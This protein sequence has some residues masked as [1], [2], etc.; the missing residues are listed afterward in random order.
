M[1]S[2]G[3]IDI[4]YSLRGSCFG[5]IVDIL[6]SWKGVAKSMK[7]AGNARLA[8]RLCKGVWIAEEQ[9]L[10]FMEGEVGN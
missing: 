3:R 8:D 1:T 9:G 7:A 4:D 5:I 6:R 10:V 2:V